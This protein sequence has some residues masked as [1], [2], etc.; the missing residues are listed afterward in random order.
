MDEQVP[1]WFE[2]IDDPELESREHA[3]RGPRFWIAIV[4]VLIILGLAV[5]PLLDLLDLGPRANHS[6]PSLSPAQQVGWKFGI[7][8]LQ[9]ASVEDAT[10]L[11]ATDQWPR[12]SSIIDERHAVDQPLLVGAQIG[13]G[14]VRCNDSAPADAVCFHAWLYTTGRPEIMRIR[15]VVSGPPDALLVTQIDRVAPRTA[16]R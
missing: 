14:V 2:N 11:A 4:T 1:D 15:Y 10:R 12:I 9:A 6:T 16:A 3:S 13:I 8:M 7:A 5:I